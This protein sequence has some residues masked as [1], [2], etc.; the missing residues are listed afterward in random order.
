[1]TEEQIDELIMALLLR[2]RSRRRRNR[3]MW[4]HLLTSERLTKGQYYTLMPQL[5]EDK[6]KFFSY[7]RMSQDTFDSLHA[8]LKVHIEKKSSCR[9]P[10]IP[11][12][13]RLAITLRYL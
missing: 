10:S 11:S 1:M 8:L 6:E 13:E 3:K 2:R 12:E 7:F 4:M 9:R 5:R